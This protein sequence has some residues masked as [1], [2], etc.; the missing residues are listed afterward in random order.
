MHQG[1][2]TYTEARNWMLMHN[3]DVLCLQESGDLSQIGLNYVMQH[4]GIFLYDDIIGTTSRGFGVYV[5]FFQN[6]RCSLAILAKKTVVSNNYIY[7]IPYYI[8][9]SNGVVAPRPIIGIYVQDRGEILEF[10]ICIQ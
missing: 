2:S 1:D 10:I 5:Y 4:L 7:P 8:S 3:I 9:M 6:G